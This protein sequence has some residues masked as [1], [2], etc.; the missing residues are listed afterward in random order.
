[1]RYAPKKPEPQMQQLMD[2]LVTIFSANPDMYGR[3]AQEKLVCDQLSEAFV[4]QEKH[5]IFDALFY[6]NGNPPEKPLPE[7][8]VIAD[9][10]ADQKTEEGVHVAAGPGSAQDLMDVSVIVADTASPTA[11]AF[12]QLQEQTQK[13]KSK[14]KKKLARKAKGKGKSKKSVYQPGYMAHKYDRYKNKRMS[15]MPTSGRANQGPKT[16]MS[17][18]FDE[19][20]TVQQ[21]SLFQA[22]REEVART[23][24]SLTEARD[25]LQD[26]PEP[27]FNP[28]TSA[29]IEKRESQ[30]IAVPDQK[31]QEARAAAVSR[32]RGRR[33]SVMNVLVP[34]S[35][36]RDMRIPALV[37]PLVE[38]ADTEDMILPTAVEHQKPHMTRKRRHTIVKPAS[39]FAFLPPTRQH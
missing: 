3:E 25:I 7:P 4:E 36:S 15:L 21:K 9:T 22:H 38:D 28:F 12:G 35:H 32:P 14:K 11:P 33:I 30:R 26:L 29:S 17:Y 20:E 19:M 2:S 8:T 13:Q 39:K 1:M 6:F 10:E 37:T 27:V 34:P 16:V 31:T 24:E 18:L 23:V 5:L